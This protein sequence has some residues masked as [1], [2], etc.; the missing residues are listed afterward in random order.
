LQFFHGK[1]PLFSDET[2]HFYC[3]QVSFDGG[4]HSSLFF[5][6]SCKKKK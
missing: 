3:Q 6:L 4:F 2:C 5:P 1:W